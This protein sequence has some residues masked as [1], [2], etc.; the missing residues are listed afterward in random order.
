[1]QALIC[2]IDVPHL[3]EINAQKGYFYAVQKVFKAVRR[4]GKKMIVIFANVYLTHY[5]LDFS[6][7]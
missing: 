3:K 2:L 1:M 7:I 6:C 4:E 5:Q